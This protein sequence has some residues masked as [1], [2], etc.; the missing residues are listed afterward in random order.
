MSPEE[1]LK[2]E[3]QKSDNSTISPEDWLKSQEKNE[4]AAA[5]GFYPPGKLKTAPEERKQR[6]A[7][8][9]RKG[10]EFIGLAAPEEPE[11]DVGRVPVSGAVGAGI[12]AALPKALQYGGKALSMVPTPATKAAGISAQ[13]LGRALGTSPLLSRTGVGAVTG[14]TADVLGQTAEQMGAPRLAG[15]LAAGVVPGISRSIAKSLVGEATQTTEK[16]A[17][18][19]ERLGIKLSPSQTRKV[20]PLPSKG[21]SMQDEANQIIFNQLATKGTGKQVDNIDAPFIA[22]RLRTLGGEFDKI[23]KGKTFKVDPAIENDLNTII[24][25]EQELG[26]AGVST[27][28][29]IADTIANKIK[30]QGM[31]KSIE[32]DDFQRLRNALSE[33]AR[34]SGSRINSFEINSLIDKIDDAVARYNPQV[35][36]Q[37]ND[38]R[39]KYRN[40]IILEDLYR[41]NGISGG[42]ISP[43]KL[44]LKLLNDPGVIRKQNISKDIDLLGE[45]GRELR[46]R[47]LWQSEGARALSDSEK[48]LGRILNAPTDI[49]SSI[50]GLRTQQARALQ[51]QIGATKPMPKKVAA[52]AGAA[53]AEISR[54]ISPSEEEE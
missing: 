22:E 20:E 48:S 36:T 29:N 54:K 6:F 7:E 11:F 21:A 17:R 15:E 44:G 1:W 32:G 45:I 50:T 4:D 13:V 25:R 33:K 46:L 8:K 26:A 31:V 5:F 27:V 43:Q 42:N 37:L 28:K 39:P 16:I 52:P 41:S 53:A 24:Q 38:L 3:N 14:A 30:T 19:A 10:A 23:Y 2:S 12:S 51:R 9:A 34:S 49:L 40:A 18:K 35:K 47:A